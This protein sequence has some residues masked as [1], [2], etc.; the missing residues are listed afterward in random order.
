M[1]EEVCLYYFVN[2]D[3]LLSKFEGVTPCSVARIPLVGRVNKHVNFPDLT[4]NSN[5]L[6]FHTVDEIW[7]TT[8]ERLN[9]LPSWPLPFPQQWLRSRWLSDFSQ[10][11]IGFKNYKKQQHYLISVRLMFGMRGI[12]KYFFIRFTRVTIIFTPI[13][14]QIT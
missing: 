14:L 9:K 6:H 3:D 4:C 5:F 1:W 12:I 7:K 10:G 2:Y 13:L 8:P 11:V